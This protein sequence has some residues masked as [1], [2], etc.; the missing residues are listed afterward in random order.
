MYDSKSTK[1]K[2]GDGFKYRDRE[3]YTIGIVREIKYLHGAIF[4]V[5]D[6]VKTNDI[7]VI[8]DNIFMVNSL[9]ERKSIKLTKDE[10]ILEQL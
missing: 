10:L 9:M 4:Y 7:T 3:Y 6:A 5:Y 1:F 8:F 2:V